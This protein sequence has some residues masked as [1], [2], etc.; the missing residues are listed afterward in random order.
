MNSVDALLY[1]A[2]LVI[3][4]IGALIDINNSKETYLH[5]EQKL[6]SVYQKID[7]PDGKTDWAGTHRLPILPAL[8]M[9]REIRARGYRVVLRLDGE[10]GPSYKD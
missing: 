7:L 10:Y 3:I 6:Y 5:T 2:A 1:L 4:F 8:R 9:F